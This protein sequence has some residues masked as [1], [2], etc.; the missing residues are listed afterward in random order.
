MEFK[1]SKHDQSQGWGRGAGDPGNKTHRWLHEGLGKSVYCATRLD[2]KE[3]KPLPAVRDDHDRV[4]RAGWIPSL[5]L[6]EHWSMH[7]ER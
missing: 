1:A 7:E 3:L 4:T 2:E 5:C 6:V